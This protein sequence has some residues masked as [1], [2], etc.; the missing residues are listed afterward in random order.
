[1][2]INLEPIGTVRTARTDLS[3]D[4]WGGLESRIELD[5]A[6]Y[7]PDALAGITD[8]SHVEV[9]FHFHQV[10]VDKIVSAARHPRG[11]TD[12]PKVGIFAQRG[13]VRPNRLAV[14]VCP[15]IAVNGLSLTVQGL[16][17]IDG[18]PV[19][20]LKPYLSGFA[21]RG[22]IKEPGWAKEIMADYW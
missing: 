16:D 18:T 12:W 15:I 2:T 17:A 3:D 20:D 6:A 1:M 14:T 8:F 4:Y 7:G 19:F 9:L 5:E 22:E 13:R 10:A 21:P 11:R